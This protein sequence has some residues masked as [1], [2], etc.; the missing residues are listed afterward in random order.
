MAPY[1]LEN[2]SH[3]TPWGKGNEISRQMELN[4]TI[5]EISGECF[6]STRPLLRNPRGVCDS[7]KAVYSESE[8]KDSAQDFTLPRE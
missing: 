6:Y 7:I 4:R 5:P 3:K 8:K 2:A 1:R